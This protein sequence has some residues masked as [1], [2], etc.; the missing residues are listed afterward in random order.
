MF[1]KKFSY[2]GD[3]DEYISS[4]QAFFIGNQ[5][6]RKGQDSFDSRHKRKASPLTGEAFQRF[7]Q[8]T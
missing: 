2:K 1:H 3:M 6:K 7:S 8:I 4:K 5:K